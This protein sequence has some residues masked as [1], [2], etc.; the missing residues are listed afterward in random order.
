MG[1][2]LEADEPADQHRPQPSQRGEAHGR[3]PLPAHKWTR[4]H[5]VTIPWIDARHQRRTYRPDFLV[6]YG[7]GALALIEVKAAN[8]AS[9]SQEVQRK[10]RAAELWCRRRGMTY[11]IATIE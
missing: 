10:R 7:D 2:R 5:G 9:D 8:R 1:D 4:K 6:Q 11:E 3:R